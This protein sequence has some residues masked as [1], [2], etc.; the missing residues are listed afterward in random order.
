V[1]LGNSSSCKFHKQKQRRNGDEKQA[2]LGDS[3][4]RRASSD[5]SAFVTPWRAKTPPGVPAIV[6][7]ATERDRTQASASPADTHS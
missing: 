2:E 7:T 1:P 5:T 4:A 3:V 6:L